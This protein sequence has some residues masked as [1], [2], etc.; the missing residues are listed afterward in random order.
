MVSAKLSQFGSSLLLVLAGALLPLSL[1]PGSA[2]AQSQ[3]DN[4]SVADAARRAREQKKKAP[5]PARILTNDDLPATPAAA[6]PSAASAGGTESAAPDQANTESETGTPAKAPAAAET[7]APVASAQK[8]KTEIEAALKRAQA[9][10]AQVQSELDVLQRKSALDRDSFY[11]QTDYAH[12]ADGKAR[13]DANAQQV[14]DKKSQVDEL[15][16]KVA[17]LQAELGK[18]AEPDKSAQP[19]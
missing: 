6:Q 9:E 1:M 3:S 5:K 14:N 13:L 12:D 8:K 4:S 10:L 17:A 18:A 15:K 11:S 2:S 19:Q 7:A 16:S